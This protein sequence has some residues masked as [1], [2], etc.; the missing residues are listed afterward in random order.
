MVSPI[1]P[2]FQ[3]S[4]G[5]LL[6]LGL[7]LHDQ[8]IVLPLIRIHTLTTSHTIDALWGLPTPPSSALH[9]LPYSWNKWGCS[10]KVWRS[11]SCS[12]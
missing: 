2:P 9:V 7:I 11:Y 10:C 6:S 4:S 5:P 3:S 12:P 1:S 8:G